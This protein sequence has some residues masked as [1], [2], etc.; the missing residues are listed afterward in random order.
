MSTKYVT[1]F[2]RNNPLKMDCGAQL[3]PVTVAYETYGELNTDGTNAV[4]V[5]HALTG[6]A[7]AS[8]YLE[9]QNGSN[10]FEEVSEGFHLSDPFFPL[11]EEHGWWN[12]VIG[13]GKA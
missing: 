10:A 6:N 4:L 7:H 9:N 8:D 13:K 5:C 1:L 2:A 12:G 3:T 11:H